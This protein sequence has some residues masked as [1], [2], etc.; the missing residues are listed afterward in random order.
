MV[1]LIIHLHSNMVLLKE[2]CM[3]LWYKFIKIYIP[4]W[5]Y[6]KLVTLVAFVPSKPIYIPI[7]YYL[8]CINKSALGFKPNNLHSNM[9]LLKV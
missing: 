9:V 1:Q 6:L 8:K 2:C 7:W 3:L 4:I 5:Y